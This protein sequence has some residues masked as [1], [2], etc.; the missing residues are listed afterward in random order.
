MT[1]KERQLL[2][3]KFHKSNYFLKENL[4]YIF[5]GGGR[6][7]LELMRSVS[8]NK[9]L[10]E[11]SIIC[12]ED[13]HENIKHS[14]KIKNLLKDN[15]VESNVTKKL[16]EADH[17]TIK[18]VKPDVI[19]V[20]GWRT[21]IDTG[22]NNFCKYGIIAAH[23]SLLPKY[24]GFAPMQWAII[25]GDKATG[26]SIFKIE[27]GGVDSGRILVQK[28]VK[29]KDQ[30][31]VN[32]VEFKLT[33][34]TVKILTD[35]IKKKSLKA[36]SFKKQDESKATYSCKRTPEDGKINWMKDS[37]E[38]YNLV[39]ALAFPY[40]GAFCFYKNE[41]F[42]IRNAVIGKMNSKK[43]SGRIPGRVIGIDET[44]I[45]VLCGSGTILI[46]EWEKTESGITELPSF[47]VRSYS[48]TLS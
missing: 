39:R 9:M 45:E 17:I 11:Y 22:L 6:G 40:T 28:K 8:E 19:I 32:D 38:I 31:C 29:I 16:S 26:V 37:G 14:D 20:F 18:N 47:L 34:L 41:K 33:K 23:Y 3:S 35:I 4:R 1:E 12:K 46:S 21:M 2:K 44:G 5:I 13:D 10:P 36:G 7:G 30:D 25:N 27:N 15:G 42:I 48:D 24:R 43:F